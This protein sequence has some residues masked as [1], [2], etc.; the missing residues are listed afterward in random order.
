M[1]ATSLPIPDSVQLLLAHLPLLK[2]QPP[3]HADLVNGG[4]QMQ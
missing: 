4:F 2:Q 3:L 1:L